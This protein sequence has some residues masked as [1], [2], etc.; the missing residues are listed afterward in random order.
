M[1]QN[2]LERI[3]SKRT[4]TR[5]RAF[6]LVELLV[7]IAIIAL[8][9][10]ILMPSL[11]KAREQAKRVVCKSNLRQI[12]LGVYFYVEDYGSFPDTDNM[13]QFYWRWT[14]NLV[15]PGVT[16]PNPYT[17]WF[18]VYEWGRSQ[19]VY[20]FAKSFWTEKYISNF[21]MLR[22]PS[23]KGD[24]IPVGSIGGYGDI[25]PQRPWIQMDVH[26]YYKTFGTSY[27]YN[28]RDNMASLDDS[29]KGSLM[30]KNYATVRRASELIV[31]GD[32]SMTSY[33][34]NGNVVDR[35]LWHDKK[36]PYANIVFADFH[37]SGIV[38]TNDKPDFLS[39]PGWTFVA[40]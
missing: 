29:V 11:Q 5:Y 24:T 2:G 10:S 28:C 31:L 9:L 13:S 1:L 16:L 15:S 7:V 18:W 39:G 19:E 3:A 22:C 23:D 40:E 32:V 34:N 27:W 38:M 14:N 30:G 26:N 33:R 6:T 35:Y 25:R 36:R 4:A 17:Y 21:K 37:V 12:A 8:L 20:N